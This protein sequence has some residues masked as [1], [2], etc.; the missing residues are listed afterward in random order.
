M[1]PIKAIVVLSAGLI[2]AGQPLL[3][4][5]LKEGL[6]EHAVGLACK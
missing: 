6:C 1:K 2:Q 3:R 5:V 4:M